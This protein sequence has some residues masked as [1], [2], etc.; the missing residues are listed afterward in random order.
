MNNDRV[1]KINM[2]LGIFCMALSLYSLYSLMPGLKWLLRGG[3]YLFIY[4]RIISLFIG[5]LLLFVFGLLLVVEKYMPAY[6]MGFI[7]A[8]LMIL[9]NL[10]FMVFVSNLAQITGSLKGFLYFIL[11]FAILMYLL[12]YYK[13]NIP[14]SPVPETEQSSAEP[15]SEAG[16]TMETARAILS[17]QYLTRMLIGILIAVAGILITGITYSIA[18]STVSGGTYTVAWGAMIVGAF[19]FFRGLFGWVKIR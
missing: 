14:V 9:S 17:R 16:M 18:S 1:R 2:V 6:K 19:E 5:Y 11:P 8:V 15:G 13:K 3:D 10:L 4:F 12:A 7:F